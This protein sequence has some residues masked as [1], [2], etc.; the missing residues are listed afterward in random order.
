M[1]AVEPPFAFVVNAIL[2]ALV[3]AMQ[4]IEQ[5]HVLLGEVDEELRIAVVGRDVAVG[6]PLQEAVLVL[7]LVGERSSKCDEEKQA[8]QRLHQEPLAQ[9]KALEETRVA[10]HRGHR[11]RGS[12]PIRFN[13]AS[14]P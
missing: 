9:R 12:Q 7:Q 4:H 3:G 1:D 13:R 6:D 2:A 11:R 5:R 8:Q 10:T 14:P